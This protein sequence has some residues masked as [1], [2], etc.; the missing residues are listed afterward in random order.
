MY[1]KLKFGTSLSMNNLIVSLFIYV[2]LLS[3]VDYYSSR[4]SSVSTLE[5][6]YYKFIID[7]YN[8]LIKVVISKTNVL[9]PLSIEY[10]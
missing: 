8:F 9:L 5:L 3:L 1:I 7:I 4:V 2:L 10:G 6:I